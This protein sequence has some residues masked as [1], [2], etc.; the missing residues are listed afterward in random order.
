MSQPTDRP[1]VQG[2]SDSGYWATSASVRIS[3][4]RRLATT[5]GLRWWRTASA[6]GEM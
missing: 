2:L 3:M 5:S 4:P 1:F 6:S